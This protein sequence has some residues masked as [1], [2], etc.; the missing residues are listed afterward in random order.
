[1]LNSDMSP[2]G[3]NSGSRRPFW[4]RRPAALGV[5]ALAAVG[6]LFILWSREPSYQGKMLSQWLGEFNR[7]P[8]DQPA[9]EAEE[10]VRTIGER[11]LPFLLSSIW[12][13]EPQQV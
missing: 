13:T 12:A 10:A 2:D 3:V 7:I 1:M 6:V 4:S 8:P 11:A 5:L 9:P